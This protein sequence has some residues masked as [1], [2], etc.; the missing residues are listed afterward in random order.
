MPARP[1]H[2]RLAVVAGNAAATG[3]DADNASGAR[4][5][6]R[7]LDWSILMARAQ[8]GDA[9]AYRRLLEEILPYLRAV[10]A[11]WHRDRS[12]I[13]DTVQDVLL[14]LHTIRQ[15]YDPN[16]PFTPWLAA[17]ASRRAVDRLRRQGR[18]RRGEAVLGG[19]YETFGRVQTNF[20]EAETRREALRRAVARLPPGQRRAV[21]LLK[22]Q[23]M[24]LKQAA[25]TSGMS[26]GALKVAMHRAMR[27]LR[28]MLGGKGG[29]A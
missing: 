20:E 15:T 26:I 3:A 14:T 23:E 29:E 28:K 6:A 9:D 22:L 12:D 25:A 1:Q 19:E 4:I 2:R 16:R 13:E 7:D 5:F 8:S 18:A 21:T 24:S 11:R 17:I 27:T 10:V